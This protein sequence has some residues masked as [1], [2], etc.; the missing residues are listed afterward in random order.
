MQIKLINTYFKKALTVLFLFITF[1]S[2]FAQIDTNLVVTFDFNEGVIKEKN[3]LVKPKPVGIALTED[4]FG[5]TNQAIYIQGNN[6]SYLNLGTS[7]LLKPENGTISLWARLDRRVYI[8]K[9]YD[10]NPI[11]GTK[12]APGEDFVIAY[13]IVYDGYSNRLSTCAT[14]DSTKEA[15]VGANEKF[16][17]GNWYHLAISFDDDFFAFYV[18]GKLQQKVPKGFK[19][20]YLEQDSVIIGHTASRKNERYSLGSFDDIQIFHRVLN[21]DEILGLYNSTNPNKTRELFKQS[22]KYVIIIIVLV[23]VIIG[24]LIRNKQKLKKQKEQL[25]LTNKI[26]E[27]ELKVVKAQ[28]NPHFIS[29]CI[30]AIQE[31][32]YANEIDKAAQY[33][34]KFSFFLRQVLYYSDKNFISIEDELEIIKLNVEL[35]QLRFKNKFS[36]ELMVSNDVDI[37]NTF[38]PSLITQPFIENA[39]W[40]GLLPLNG[41]R[42]AELKIRIY[43]KDNLP[44]IEIEDNGV[45][46]KERLVKGHISKGTKLVEDKIESL[47]KLSQSSNYRLCIKDL[48]DENGNSVGTKVLIQLDDIKYE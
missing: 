28:M 39:I 42:N 21:D 46:R 23:I 43:K 45:G 4:R 34:A 20:K 36:Y 44:I 15:L 1:N 35:E 11:I 5:N 38:T 16:I 7:G 25:E 31:L 3:N 12:N 32:I 47:N 30:A 24:L 8:G 2:V 17:F 26:S 27:L 13:T 41:E 33:L 37:A 29:N 19:S 40:H 6:F 9:G 14:L 18:N 48:N 10:S 22:L